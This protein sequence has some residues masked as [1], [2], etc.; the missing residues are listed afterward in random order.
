M[1]MLTRLQAAR[2]TVAE[3]ML[4]NAAYWVIFE[5]LEREIEIE[6]SRGDPVARART[7]VAVQRAMA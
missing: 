2:A 7:I 1:S 4:D 5:R 3:L 6:E